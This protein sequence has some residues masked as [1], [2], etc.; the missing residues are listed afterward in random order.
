MLY[1]IAKYAQNAK[2]LTVTLQK[3]CT[4]NSFIPFNSGSKA[5]KTAGKSNYIKN[6]QT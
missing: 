5:H 6:T 3:Y 1:F 4:V 2:F